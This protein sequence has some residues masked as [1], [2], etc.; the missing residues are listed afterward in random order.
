[1]EKLYQFGTVNSFLILVAKLFS[2]MSRE[3]VIE[4][5]IRLKIVHIF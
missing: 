5:K 1:M 4:K 3:L 2:L